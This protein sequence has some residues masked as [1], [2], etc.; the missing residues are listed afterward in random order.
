MSGATRRAAG[1]Q[2]STPD[3]SR[4]SRGGARKRGVRRESW[5][6]GAQGG[7]AIGLDRIRSTVARE[8]AECARDDGQAAPLSTDRFR[9]RAS[10]EQVRHREREQPR[11]EL[12]D[13]QQRAPQ[14]VVVV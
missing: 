14:Q 10:V 5:S 7:P 6:G 2:R 4:G 9:K 3:P 8:I 11:M 1:A 12:V 13:E